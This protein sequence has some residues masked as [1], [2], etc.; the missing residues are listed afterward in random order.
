[1]ENLTQFNQFPMELDNDYNPEYSSHCDYMQL[2]TP[3]ELECNINDSGRIPLIPI[4]STSLS[5]MDW[6]NSYPNQDFD[7]DHMAHEWSETRFDFD[8]D[9]ADM[10]IANIDL[11]P[12]MAQ[13]QVYSPS[14]MFWPLDDLQT[15]NMFNS[16]SPPAVLPPKC[17]PAQMLLASRTYPTPESSTASANSNQFDY[18][19]GSNESSETSR[20]P[21]KALSKPSYI[22]ETC[23][24]EYS[25]RH[26]LK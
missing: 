24:V 6:T 23:G 11:N 15:D 22:C 12:A 5:S 10:E 7:L 20:A 18:Y 13:T 1:M 4:P 14:Q 2:Q 25:R 17:Y 16:I 3:R 26:L 8:H 19:D 21:L 9:W